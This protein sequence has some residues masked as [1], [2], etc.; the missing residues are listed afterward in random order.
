MDIFR[1]H[2]AKQ[3]PETQR[4]GLGQWFEILEEK[5][6]DLI[7]VNFMTVLCLSPS[8]ICI[9]LGIYM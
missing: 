4:R 5:I 8:V 2:F 3:P 7:K 1:K 9:C 6:M